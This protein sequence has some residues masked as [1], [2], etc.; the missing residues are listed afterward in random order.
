[1]QT[2]SLVYVALAATMGLTSCSKLGPLAADNFNVTPTP[3][4]AVSNQV[5]ATINGRFPAKYMKKK[6]VITVTPVLRYENGE[7]V[8]VGQTFQGQ[9]V[10]G[11]QQTVNYKNGGSFVIRNNFNYTDAM[12]K[13]DLY[14]VF[15]GRIGKRVQ[16]IPAV[17]IGHGILATSTLINRTVQN[18]NTAV[19][20]NAYQKDI[21]K[22]Q[23]ASILYLINQAKVRSSQVKSQSVQ[24]FV[25]MLQN[26]KADQK[27]LALGNVE[28][29]AFASPDGKY[30]FNSKLAQKRENTSAKYVQKQ[31]KDLDIDATLDTKYTAEDWEGFKKLVEQ[32]NIQDKDVILRVLSMYKDP[33]ERDKQIRNLSAAFRELADGILPE[34]RRARLTINYTVVGR[35]DSEIAQQ[36]ADNAEVLPLE[37]ILYYAQITPSEK[38]Q[39]RIYAEA[40]RLYKNDWRA[41]N[42]LGM[43]AFHEGNFEQAQAYFASAAAIQADAT[44]LNA[45]RALLALAQG[46]VQ[47]AERFAGK[48][49]GAPNYNEILG[50]IAIAKGQYEKA[51]QLLEGI[52]SNSAA[53]ADILTKNYAAAQE[54]LDKVATPDATTSYLRAI[55]AA[56]T[57]NSQAAK[58]YLKQ[59]FEKN[60]QLRARADKDI[61]FLF[62]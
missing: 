60:P 7:T 8:G 53:L 38:E 54:V 42:N 44:E 40:A 23:E 48:A 61:E 11:N 47:E 57:N 52:N 51:V 31:L 30:E 21:Q 22:K 41:F 15:D 56:R 18:A 9:K 29:S 4:E 16:N 43:E 6:A 10:M 14:L 5:S 26:I 36:F 13:S 62:L 33:E 12:A 50:N 24:E 39:K 32:S 59:A 58:Q 55:L 17:K 1:M 25:Q 2:K 3:L 46:H 28:V 34:L 19:G 20:H 49:A 45:N 27:G 37:E 35:T